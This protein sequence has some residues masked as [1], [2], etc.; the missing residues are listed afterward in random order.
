ML[1]HNRITIT[2]STRV[3]SHSHTTVMRAGRSTNQ[4]WSRSTV[5]RIVALRPAGDYPTPHGFYQ[6]ADS[7]MRCA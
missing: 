4:Y 6:G 3:Y 5:A 7:P 2:S 1:A